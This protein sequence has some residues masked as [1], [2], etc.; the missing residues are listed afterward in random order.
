MSE[1]REVVPGR[2]WLVTRRCTQ[3]QYF[4]RPGK[5]TKDIFDYCLAEAAEKFGIE[6]IAWT[7]MSNHYHVVLRDVRGELPKFMHRLNVH[8]AKC[9]NVQ[10]KRWENLWSSDPACATHLVTLDDVFDS[11]VYTLANPVVADLV[12]RAREWPGASSVKQMD[13]S[14]KDLKRPVGYFREDGVMPKKVKL[15]TTPLQAQCG[16]PDAWRV[17]VLNALATRESA[18]ARARTDSG[19]RVVGFEALVSM[20]AF[21]QPK[22]AEKKMALRPAIACKDK[23]KRIA[24]IASLKAFRRAHRLAREAFARRQ[25]D[26]IFPA[27]TWMMR[28]LGVACRPFPAPA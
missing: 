11:V 24:A 16:S 10:W 9:L 7:A 3:R 17:R 18:A 14:P 20:S 25:L 15:R 23:W 12:E 8:L 19:K 4:L 1:P 2:Y 13:G 21:E 27:G 5:A 26:V 22:T 6:L 28:L